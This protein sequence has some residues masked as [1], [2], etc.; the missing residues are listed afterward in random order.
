MAK[1]SATLQE[2]IA[3]ARQLGPVESA[4]SDFITN[5]TTSTSQSR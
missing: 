3:R 2:A 4:I 5:S 1:G